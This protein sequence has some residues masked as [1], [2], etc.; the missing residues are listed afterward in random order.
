MATTI[1]CRLDELEPS[2]RKKEKFFAEYVLPL[3]VK[4]KFEKVWDGKKG[5]TKKFLKK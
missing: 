1:K 5:F 4:M 3:M 2:T